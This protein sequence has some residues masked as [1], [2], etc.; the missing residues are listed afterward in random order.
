MTAKMFRA[1]LPMAL[2]FTMVSC[3][4]DS[5]S[6]ELVLQQE[7]NSIALVENYDYDESELALFTLINEHRLSLNLPALQ[8]DHPPRRSRPTIPPQLST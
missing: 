8:P 6:D 7:S 4:S 2:L 5:D 3:S 1:L